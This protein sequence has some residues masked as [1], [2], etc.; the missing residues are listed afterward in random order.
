[1]VDTKTPAAAPLAAP[2]ALAA[3]APLEHAFSELERLLKDREVG[4]ALAERGAREFASL[5]VVRAKQE[6]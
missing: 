3:L 4:C 5:L 6:V 1:M 2:A